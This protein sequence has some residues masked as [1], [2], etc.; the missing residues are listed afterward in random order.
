MLALEADQHVAGLFKGKH[1]RQGG[2]ALLPFQPGKRSVGIRQQV[3]QSGAIG[4]VLQHGLDQAGKVG[5]DL[6]FVHVAFLSVGKNNGIYLT[7]RAAFPCAAR[8]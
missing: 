3:S 5:G 7:C 1:H 6:F 2:P 4:W 8:I